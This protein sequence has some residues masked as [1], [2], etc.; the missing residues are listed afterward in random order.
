[1]SSLV[2]TI[3][4]IF[5]DDIGFLNI[6]RQPCVSKLRSSIDW[7]TA[8]SNVCNETNLLVGTGPNLSSTKQKGLNGAGGDRKQLLQGIN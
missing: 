8:I 6:F 4:D 2:C 5:L 1:M 3:T 7:D